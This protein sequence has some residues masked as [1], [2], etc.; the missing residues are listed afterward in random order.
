MRRIS[1]CLALLAL[2]AT[3]AAASMAAEPAVEDLVW[4]TGS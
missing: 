1:T 4:L 3:G 2:T